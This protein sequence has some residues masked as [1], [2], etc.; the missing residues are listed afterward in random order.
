MADKARIP[1][2]SSL[3]RARQRHRG[4]TEY[5]AP[6]PNAGRPANGRLLF[7]SVAFDQRYA[8]IDNRSSMCHLVNAES[9]HFASLSPSIFTRQLS[10]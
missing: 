4:P 10:Q 2:G 7:A 3:S 6:L 9:C 5:E 8:R 1:R